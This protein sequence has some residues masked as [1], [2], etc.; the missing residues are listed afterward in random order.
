MMSE[1]E[2]FLGNEA[3]QESWLLSDV[4][5]SS[6]TATFSGTIT[7]ESLEW[8][9]PKTIRCLLTVEAKLPSPAEN[10]PSV[11]TS[12]TNIYQNIPRLSP[13]AGTS[14]PIPD[15]SELLVGFIQDNLN[16]P[17]AL[18]S[19]YNND[20]IDPVQEKNSTQHILRANDQAELIMDDKNP[21]VRFNYQKNTISLTQDLV[22][23]NITGN[24]ILDASQK[25]IYHSQQNTHEICENNYSRAVQK[26]FSTNTQTGNMNYQAANN[27][28]LNSKDNIH[29]SSPQNITL[30]SQ[31]T[32][33][34]NATLSLMSRQGTT[35]T[36]SGEMNI[37]SDND[38]TI[39]GEENIQICLGSS[40]IEITKDGIINFNAPSITIS[41]QPIVS[42]K[43]TSPG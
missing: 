3:W 37:S 17:I 26:N 6:D 18:G 23:N 13:S 10:H 15:N 12:N 22:I 39:I 41:G 24:I 7:A 32:V 31:A 42:V 30:Q 9:D 8:V 14:W 5:I 25:M 36:S 16:Q 43:P 35:I 40:V 20:K 21:T 29:L 33:N 19:L 2:L 1:I 38:L 34:L 27:L 11:I 4:T 28:E